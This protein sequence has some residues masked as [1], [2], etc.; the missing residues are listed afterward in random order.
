MVSTQSKNI[1]QIGSFP[2]V[3]VNMKNIWNHH[4]VTCFFCKD[5]VSSK[6]ELAQCHP[7]HLQLRR[8]EGYQRSKPIPWWDHIAGRYFLRVGYNCAAISLIIKRQLVVD[9]W[10]SVMIE[11]ILGNVENNRM[12]LWESYPWG[13]FSPAGGLTWAG[14]RFSI[15]WM[16][17]LENGWK[18]DHFLL[19][20]PH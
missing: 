9:W 3:R 16:E 10:L 19:Y 4:L 7:G 2:Q 17:R 13:G 5:H 6:C 1:R 11:P 12:L 18:K 8:V 20:L 14:C 15:R